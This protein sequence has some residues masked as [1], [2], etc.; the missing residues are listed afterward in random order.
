MQLLPNFFNLDGVFI[1]NFP[2]QGLWYCFS[3][4]NDRMLLSIGPAD[5]ASL[6]VS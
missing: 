6:L 3:R 1:K 5:R 2:S 4:V